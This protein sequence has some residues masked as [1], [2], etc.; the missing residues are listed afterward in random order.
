MSNGEGISDDAG[1]GLDKVLLLYRQPTIYHF[2][3][4]DEL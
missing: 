4:D 3:Q 1:S 2:E